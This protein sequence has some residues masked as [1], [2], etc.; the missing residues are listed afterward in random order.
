MHRISLPLALAVLCLL[1]APAAALADGP[2]E[3]NETA[4]T[5]T[6][7]LLQSD[8]G[9]GL[10]TPQD[11]DWYVLHLRAPKQVGVL[12]TLAA[13]CRTSY[14]RLSVD[15]LDADVPGF[16]NDVGSI[17]LGRSD[18]APSGSGQLLAGRTSFTSKRGH[19]Y[20]LKVTQSGCD[21]AAYTISLAHT[22]AL[23]GA[24]E[25]TAECQAAKQAVTRARRKA[26]GLRKALRRARGTRR[27]SLR[28]RH[29]IAQQAVAVA[30]GERS[31]RCTRQDITGYP[32]E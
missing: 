31:S 20:F 23:T 1:V 10:E 13:P 18:A 11:V 8:L 2:F 17:R 27:T 19:R 16:G 6:G 25:I 9:A 12:A 5:A 7:P 30:E 15:L 29:R 22:N 28:L 24:L 21:S 14:G 4:A 32:W 3:P 26:A